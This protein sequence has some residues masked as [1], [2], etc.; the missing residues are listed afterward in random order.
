MYSYCGI[1]EEKDEIFMVEFTYAVANPR[2]MMIHPL[3]ALFAY[4]AM[5]ES[6]LF[7]Q[8]AFK[9]VTDFVQR[10]DLLPAYMNPYILTSCLF[11]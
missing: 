9:T 10:S 1:E 11:L 2:A 7:D 5:V 3:Y 8:I 6:L 4:S